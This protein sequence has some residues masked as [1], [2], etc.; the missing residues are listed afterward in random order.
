[1]QHSSPTFSEA[2]GEWLAPAGGTL[3]AVVFATEFSI[4]SELLFALHCLIGATLGLLMRHLTAWLNRAFRAHAPRSRCGNCPAP[5]RTQCPP[6]VP[7]LCANN[8]P[9]PDRP[10]AQPSLQTQR[11]DRFVTTDSIPTA[12]PG[13]YY[14]D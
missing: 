8:A 6:T 12:N 4:T 9:Q 3:G 13:P 11:P 5:N 2:F 7:N 14:D 10:P 1:M